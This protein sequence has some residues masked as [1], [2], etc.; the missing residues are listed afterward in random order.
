MLPISVL[1]L[2]SA[3]IAYIVL[4]IKVHLVSMLSPLNPAGETCC[5]KSIWLYES[6]S[7]VGGALLVK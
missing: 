2:S 3:F 6:S 7:E 1:S 5:S 4:K